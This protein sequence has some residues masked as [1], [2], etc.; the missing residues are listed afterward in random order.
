SSASSEKWMIRLQE[1]E[2]RLKAEREARIRDRD[3]ARQR[4]DEALRE[5]E[6]L[7]DALSKAR[8]RTTGTFGTLGPLSAALGRSFGATADEN[9]RQALRSKI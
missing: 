6:N 5:N 2:Q 3:G 9:S 7:Q 1:L 8:L 4:L